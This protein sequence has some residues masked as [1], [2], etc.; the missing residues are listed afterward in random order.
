MYLKNKHSLT[1]RL[2]S[3]LLVLSMTCVFVVGDSFYPIIAG[4][5]EAESND[6]LAQS[7]GCNTGLSPYTELKDVSELVLAE[8]TTPMGM[9]SDSL[10]EA[11]SAMPETVRNSTEL[12]E[13]VSDFKQQIAVFKTKSLEE[14][15]KT[16]NGTE[17]FRD[18]KD[19][20]MSGYNE[21]ESYLADITVENYEKIMAD[22]S[23]LVNPEKPY[24]SLADNLPSGENEKNISSAPYNPEAVTDYQAGDPNYSADDLKQTNDTAITDEIRAEFAEYESVLEVYQYIRNSYTTEFYTGSRKG[25]AGAWA[26]KA[27][28]DYD[29]AS[30]LIGIL[31]DRNIPARYAK[32]EIEITAEQAMKWTATDNIEAAVN[33][34]CSLGIPVISMIDGEQT[35]AVRL[36]HVWAEVYVPYTDYRGTGNRSGERMWI[37]LDASFKEMEHFD[38]VKIDDIKGYIED[39]AN[40]ISSST[41][42]Y[43]TDISK[44]AGYA[45]AE[46]SALIK[47][48]LENGYGESSVAET[49][50]GKSIMGSDL[51]YLPLSLPYSSVGSAER[52]RD[53]PDNETDSV[54]FRLYGNSPMGENIIDDDSINYTY[55]APDVYGKRVILSYVP[56]TQKDADTIAEYGD[57][58]STP[59]YLIKMKPQLSIDGEVVAEGSECNAGYMQHFII[60]VNNISDLGNEP[61]FE[62]DIE[63]GGMYCIGMDYGN[64]SGSAL[65]ASARYMNSYKDS[66]SEANIY[67]EEVMGGMLDSI[68]KL[69]FGQNDL[70]NRILEG[71]T[72]VT[73]TRALSIG[74]IGFKV[75]VAYTFNLPSELNEGGFYLDIGH[76]IHNVIS[77]TNNTKDESAFMLQSGIYGSAM[78][79]GVLEQVTGIES[80]STIKTFQ[81]AAEHDI[82]LY[83]ISSENIK[84]ELDELHVSNSVKQEI[85]ESVSAGRV[86]IIP[87]S[88]MTINQWTGVG[89]MVL[90]PE[91]YVCGYMISGGTAGGAMSAL[92]VIDKYITYVAEGLVGIILY[93]LGKAAIMAALPFGW[94][95]TVFTVVE[96]GMLLNYIYGIIDLFVKFHD[97]GKVEYL[98]EALIQ[99]AA[100]LTI[101]AIMPSIKS[102]LEQMKADVTNLVNSLK[103]QPE[104]P[105]TPGGCFIAGTLISTPEGLVPIEEIRSGD[106]VWSFDPETLEVSEKQVNQVLVH[107]SNDL[108]K[109]A[110]GNEIITATSNHPFY[111]VT[112]GFISALELRAGDILINVN[113]ESV[114]VDKVQHE[115]LEAPVDVFNFSIRNNHTYFVGAAAVGVH[116]AGG[117]CAQTGAPAQMRQSSIDTVINETLNGKGNFTSSQTLTSSEAL[118]SGIDFLGEG[119]TEIGKPGSGVY[120]N[121]VNGQIRQFR[122]DNNSI[123]GNHAPNQPHVHLEIIDPV[124]NKPISNNHIIFTEP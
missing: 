92:E 47:Y 116:N 76:D 73:N 91:T 77:N 68:S 84:D 54:V 23:A 13:S 46:K 56:A 95:G 87:A 79:H 82:P 100:G 120:R 58:F 51:G 50:G 49:F 1:K 98:Q 86:V 3:M 21:I 114:V 117:P 6:L 48:L 75:N 62:N 17:Q 63:V 101:A 59:A 35:V 10:S 33:I 69:Y 29:I 53:I 74:I 111:A 88:E 109:I 102:E 108:V 4:K 7:L 65:E 44:L 31:R 27:A 19:A 39:P 121:T 25:A 37:P 97:T 81:Y 11:L 9:T 8:N 14:L 113:G 105:T 5:N 26:E 93:E 45:D 18:Y 115:I 34:M 38:G 52:F 41:E 40:Q 112:K 57:I 107:Q 28:N 22:I 2:I 83:M 64:I 90:D 71:Q 118:Q 43:G 67:S 122:M 12:E 66:V 123:C 78:E 36:E 106:V 96:L 16:D 72:N 30:L 80:V 61:T 103:A 20:I 94:V 32:G 85:T 70:Y 119:Y 110:V 89:Y 124:T 42:L 24:V 15:D 99:I 104:Y 60:S 55:R